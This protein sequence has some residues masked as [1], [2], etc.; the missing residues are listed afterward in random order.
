[1]QLGVIGL[2]RMGGNIA[3]RIHRHGHQAVAYDTNEQAVS[4]LSAEGITGA[5]S[6]ANMVEQLTAPRAL[7][8]MLPAGA[9]TEQTIHDLKPLLKAGDIIIDGGNS[10]YKDDIRRAAQLAQKDIA[11]VD[12]GTSGGVWGLDR[13]HRVSRRASRSDLQRIGTR[14]RQYREDPQSQRA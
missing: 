2:G 3:R 1:M 5:S 9:I 10:F 11:Y 12:V 13:R 6:L 8:I 4:S 14:P 7:W